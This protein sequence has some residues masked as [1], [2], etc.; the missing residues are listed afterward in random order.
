MK[1][2]IDIRRI[3]GY[4][5]IGNIF[6]KF[7]LTFSL[8]L[9]G[10]SAYGDHNN[11]RWPLQT[12]GADT[13]A[14]RFAPPAGAV[15]TPLAAD[16]FGYWLRHLPLLAPNAPVRLYDG[17]LKD[18][19]D[20]HAAVVDLDVGKNDLQQC[21]DAVMRLRAEYL[22]TRNR[23][24]A[25]HPQPGK[26]PALTWS[27]GGRKTFER[28]LIK[29]FA[30][31]GS[32]SLQAELKRAGSRPVEVG[33]VLIQGGYPGHAVLVVDA[34]ETREGKRYI[35]V[36]QSYMPAQQFHLLKNLNNPKLSPWY[37]AA[38]L[39]AAGLATPELASFYP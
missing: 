8:C 12:D 30:S 11:Y 1:N 38:D 4:R 14:S 26:P 19:Q 36:G 3:Y 35:L 2:I 28:Y 16:S 22:Y 25:F 6:Y 7:V 24:V 18:R 29:V 20:V 13:V 33:D 34:A 5:F 21:A 27:G 15:R 39:D 17:S 10:L 31:A 32:A 23:P 37:D 9:I